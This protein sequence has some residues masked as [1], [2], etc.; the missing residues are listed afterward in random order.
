MR[1]NAKLLGLAAGLAAAISYVLCAI[2]VALAPVATARTFSYV[3]HINLSSL[4][5]SLTWGS[6][7]VGM[8]MFSVTVGLLVSLAGL[9]YSRLLPTPRDSISQRV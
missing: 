4:S 9:I 5:R 2:A 3:M 1:F 7:L 6:F 8:M